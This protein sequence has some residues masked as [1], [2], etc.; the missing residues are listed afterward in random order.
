MIHILEKVAS[1][2]SVDLSPLPQVDATDTQL[3]TIL[4]IVFSISASLAL[5]FIVIGGIRY[6]LSRGDSN[7]TAQAKD[8]I[9]YAVVGLV[10][11]VL[12]YAIVRLVAGRVN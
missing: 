8:T 7:A 9:I 10:L 5:L 1:E 4:N 6:V 3:Q 12:A 11:T 2:A